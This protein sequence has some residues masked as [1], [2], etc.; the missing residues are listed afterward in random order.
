MGVAITAQEHAE[1]WRKGDTGTTQESQRGAG[2]RADALR[3]ARKPLERE[4]RGRWTERE[5]Q[6]ASLRL[7][8]LVPVRCPMWGLVHRLGCVSSWVLITKALFLND[9][10]VSL[11]SSKP[12][13][14]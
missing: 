2:W 11:C 1:I 12:K 6:R 3:K 7:L 4:E 9:I 5:Q 13:R 14:F 10:P 8:T